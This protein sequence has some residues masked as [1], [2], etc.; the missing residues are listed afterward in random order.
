MF[1]DP[2]RPNSAVSEGSDSG[3]SPSEPIIVTDEAMARNIPTP[4]TQEF[5]NAMRRIQDEVDSPDIT[6]NVSPSRKPPSFPTFGTVEEDSD[7]E[8]K[9]LKKRRHPCHGPLDPVSKA[10]AAFHR[11]IGAC[12]ECKARRTRVGATKA[13]QINPS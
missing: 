10:R 8:S 1:D 6:S 11:K 5:Y 2:G 7:S 3:G 12:P 4:M 13:A 9:R